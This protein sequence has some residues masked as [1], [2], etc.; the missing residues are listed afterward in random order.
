MARMTLDEL[1]L[2]SDKTLVIHYSCESFYDWKRKSSPRVTSVA[3]RHLD[4]G[5]T[6]SFSIHQV[7]ERNSELD[8]IDSDYDDLERQMLQKFYDF[9]GQHKE[10]R[11]LHWNMRDV[12]FGFAALE[13]RFRVLGGTPTVI[14]DSQKFD[15]PRILVDIYGVGYTAHPRLE[16][17]LEKNRIVPLNFMTGA[18]EAAAFEEGNYVGLHQ[19]TLRKVDMIANVAGRA[20]ERNLN[21][22]P[23]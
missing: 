4:S 1:F 7:A 14:A 13:H 6:N 8:E 20:R 2:R 5:Q 19:S 3:I 22:N 15:L 17:L 10:Y 18:Q 9:V 23:A 12:N 21:L 11:W 16:T